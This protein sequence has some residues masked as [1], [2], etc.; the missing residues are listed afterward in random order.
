MHFNNWAD[1]FHFFKITSTSHQIFRS[2]AASKP[3]EKEAR[4]ML[5]Q[6][7]KVVEHSH[8]CGTVKRFSCL[9]W[10]MLLRLWHER[11]QLPEVFTGTSRLL[12]QHMLD[13]FLCTSL[14]LVSTSTSIFGRSRSLVVQILI[15]DSVMLG[16]SLFIHS[17]CRK[18]ASCSDC[19]CA[20]QLTRCWKLTCVYVCLFLLS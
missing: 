17:L 6:E 11:S 9:Y 18:F 20:S 2:R 3:A 7:Q 5:Q 14:C 19:L 12:T 13:F 10:S 15:I 1:A 8:R 4:Q 16:M